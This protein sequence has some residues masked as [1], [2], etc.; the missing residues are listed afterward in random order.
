MEIRRTIGFSIL[1]CLLVAC[2]GTESEEALIARATESLRDGRINAAIIDAKSAL[3]QNPRNRE[4][5]RVLGE[6]YLGQRNFEAAIAELERALPAGYRGDENLTSAFDSAGSGAQGEGADGA[7]QNTAADIQA[8]VVYAQALVEAGRFDQLF[9][10]HNAADLPAV[11]DDPQYLAAVARALVQTGD[12]AEAQAM[13]EPALTA[14]PGD[15]YVQLSKAIVDVRSGVPIEDVRRAVQQLVDTH[16]YNDDAWGLLAELARLSGDTA[17]AVDAF[18]QAVKL[19]RFRLGD[20]LNLLALRLEQE[21]F[22]GART[23]IESLEKIIPDHPGVSFAKARLLLEASD[24]EAA[25][26]ELNN[27]LAAAPSHGPS[28]YLAGMVNAREGNLSTA[29]R[30]LQRYLQSQPDN[31]TARQQLANLHLQLDD[32][33]A[34]EIVAREILEED[35]MDIPALRILAV[36]LSLQGLHVES[37]QAFQQVATL[38]PDA[39]DA[40]VGLGTAQLRAGNLDSG[41]S[42]LEAAL[43][44]E[45]DDAA[46]NER[47]INVYLA[48]GQ[49]ERAR[50]LAAAYIAREPENA[51]AHL[52]VGRI[53]LQAREVDSAKASFSRALELEP[54]NVDALG[55]L[56]ATALLNEDIDSARGYFQE[57]LSASPDNLSVLMN[58]A[59]IE[60]ASGNLD[61]MRSALEQAVAA[62]PRV[63]APRLAL[64]RFR[65]S[66]GQASE[67][68]ELLQGMVAEHPDVRALHEVLA[69]ARLAVGDAASALPNAAA[70]V[71]LAPEAVPALLL[72]AR[73]EQAAG[74]LEQARAHLELILDRQAGN[75]EARGL[76]VDNLLSSGELEAAEGEIAKLPE[77]IVQRPPVQVVLGR[78]E[79]AR[80]QFADAE[81]RFQKAHS[82]APSAAYAGWLAAAQWQGGH[83]ETSMA[84][85]GDWLK[86]HPD[87]LGIRNELANR[88]LSLGEEPMAL[89]QFNLLLERLPDNP[90][91]LNNVA[92]LERESDPAR[93]LELI[94]RADELAPDNPQIK[95][96]YAIVELANGNVGSAKEKIEEALTLAPGNAQIELNRA[97]VLL[98]VEGGEAPVARAQA[99]EILGR[100]AAMPDFPEAG[101]ARELLAKASEAP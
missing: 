69:R 8:V 91:I 14:A 30:Q 36:A 70:L 99:R 24:F 59:I 95:D 73:V 5:R 88:Y 84:T 78:I 15:Q 65:L 72:A 42:E 77:D 74:R 25:L 93:A 32:P 19:N 7:R 11:E 44:L 101:A 82:E 75:N 9:E 86:S 68:V 26:N 76:L 10:L 43:A 29:L 81:A 34:A 97:R 2:G 22:E 56:A 20:R 64:A 66:D 58:L 94:R 57:A 71:R 63:L 83:R 45:P 23:D 18:T 3:Q 50:D 35:S 6:A 41:I 67:A 4:A 55:G 61:A 48:A 31:L 51:R 38:Q 40:R 62:H 100:L 89:S 1:L 90:V 39:A 21:D 49:L 12:T 92:W 52:L 80:G 47:L 85:L 46:L 17:G 13:L 79:L 98:A 28:L 37:A 33:R 60:E 54:T 27:V 16:P 96:T 87:D 53:S